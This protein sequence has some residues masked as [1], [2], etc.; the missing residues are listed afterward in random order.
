MVLKHFLCPVTVR[1]SLKP[2]KGGDG[3]VIQFR[4]ESQ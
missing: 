3:L 1:V 4:V 2:L